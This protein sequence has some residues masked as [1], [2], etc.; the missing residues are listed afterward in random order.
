MLYQSWCLCVDVAKDSVTRDQRHILIYPKLQGSLCFS[1]KNGLKRV[2]SSLWKVE[3]M[4]SRAMKDTI[5]LTRK[6]T[7]SKKKKPCWLRK[8]TKQKK[9]NQE[10]NMKPTRPHSPPVRSRTTRLRFH[11]LVQKWGWFTVHV[12]MLLVFQIWVYNFERRHLKCL[13]HH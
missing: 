3:K 8:K 4:S 7:R 1:G 13:G 9:P 5:N 2:F 11:S 6:S 10:S 12:D